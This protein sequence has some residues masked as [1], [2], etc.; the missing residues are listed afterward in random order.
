MPPI[1]TEPSVCRVCGTGLFGAQCPRCLLNLGSSFGLTNDD[2]ADAALLDRH[3][4]R[5]FGDYELLEEIARGGMGVVYR[6]RQLS[7]G[8]EVAV[9][10]ILAGELASRESL[11]MFQREAHA[12]ANLHNP[13]IVPVYEIGE[14]QTQHYFTMRFVPGGKT[15]ADW[16]AERRGDFRAIASASSK[17]ARAVAHAHAHGVLHRDLK[18]SNILWDDEA[19]PQVTDF[20]L[21]KLLNDA[22][23]TV[24]RAAQVIGSPSYMAPEQMGG[25]LAEITTA[26]DVYGL[27]AVLYELLSGE[28][29]FSG[30][31]VIETMRR[32]ADTAPAPLPRVPKD[33]HTVCMKCLAKK[34]EDRY[35]SVAALAE[36]LERFAR[37]EPV[38]A[39]PLSALQTAWRWAQRRPTI[40]ALIAV[41]LGLILAGMGGVVWQ[42]R[43]TETALAHLQWQEIGR[44]L[45]EGDNARALAYLA[46]LIRADPNR[47]SAAMYAMSIVEQNAYPLLAG[48]EIYP[49]ATLTTPAQLSPDGTW[50]AAA[51]KDWIVR[52]WDVA[53]GKEKMQLPQGAAIT[54]LAVADRLAVATNEGALMIYSKLDAQPAVLAR[55]APG[56]IE[57]LRFSTDGSRLLAQTKV[58]VEIWATETSTQS[59]MVLTLDGEIKG[60][61]FSGDGSRALLWNA[62]EAV[63]WDATTDKELLRIQPNEEFRGGAIAADG[64]RAALLDGNFLARTWEV[65][66]PR[67]FP[68][69][70]TTLSPRNFLAFDASGT[71][72]TLAGW[73]NDLSVHDVESGLVV[74]PKMEHNYHVVG[75]T[76]SP[77]GSRT[78]SF[79][80]D[81]MIHVWDARSGQ[82]LVSPIRLQGDRTGTEMIPSRDGSRVLLDSPPYD[83]LPETLSVWQSSTPSL[84]QRHRID[85]MRNFDSST[86]SP[87]G[88]LG[89]I[90][91]SSDGGPTR[92]HVY[93]LATDKVVLDKVTD[94]EVYVTLFSPDMR[95]CYALTVNGWLYGFSL[96]TGEPLWPPNHQPDK[97]RPAAISSDGARIIAGFN[98]R[99]RIYDTATGEQVQTLDHPGEIK[100]LRFAPDNSGRFL[101][102]G[103]DHLAHVWDLKTG[104][105]LQTFRGHDELI[106]AS[107]WSPDSRYVATGSY[108]K[109]A[110][111]WDVK[112]GRQIGASMPHLGDLAHLEFSPDGT[113]L[114]TACRDGTVRLW[115]PLTGR[116]ISEPLRQGQ[117]CGTVR[118]TADGATFF[119]HDHT[120]FRFWNTA[121]AE[122]VTVHYPEA[123]AGGFAMDCKSRHAFITPDGAQVFL[124][125]SMNYGAHWTV[126]QPRGRAP[127]WFPDFLEMLCQ[128]RLDARG[129]I[130]LIP[131]EEATIFAAGI[132]QAAANDEYAAWA[133][134]ILGTENR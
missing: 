24:T 29:P 106:I 74:S 105:K 20:G 45:D 4:V 110:R 101:S 30:A 32:A 102:G 60:V 97:M 23:S 66:S 84:S 34:Q 83:G 19:G 8:R 94:Q 64:K 58:K 80:W 59:P 13:N 12:A 48:P 116:P 18:P 78:F 38:S 88:R 132:H 75:L 67:I 17:A 43:K 26:T 125:Y 87:D 51:G 95:R 63:V 52:V 55:T 11:R 96:E 10:M 70:E 129:T 76:S 22:D 5:S 89:A 49:P 131:H 93:E 21:A 39:V 82:S 61:D 85:G 56:P 31:S 112:N 41:C 92:L 54:A 119:V 128:L 72:L 9:K 73:G 86:L 122:P 69:I 65:D 104:A 111:V 14:H 121:T 40:A 124:G 134:K 33:L 28:P 7:L 118:F 114:A 57:H 6:A 103:S 50:I 117:A 91:T 16:A 53:S 130:Q 36:D 108:D 115:A 44:W 107:A 100:T 35:P 2:A 27:G 79:G 90:G 81:N 1:H 126:P 109:T 98:D 46:S 123:V 133:R 127:D 77:D 37:G 99:I 68:T 62:K 71:R 3:Q 25:H 120:G 15:I 47:W 42:W 113:R